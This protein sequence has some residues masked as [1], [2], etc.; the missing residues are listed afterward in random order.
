MGPNGFSVN[1][2]IHCWDIVDLDFCKAIGEF[3][4]VGFF[5]AS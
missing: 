5:A 2:Y 3:F 4:I 1:F